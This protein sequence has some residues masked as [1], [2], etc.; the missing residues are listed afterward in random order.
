MT[1]VP[2]LLSYLRFEKIKT[3]LK[4]YMSMVSEH[5]ISF[6]FTVSLCFSHTALLH[7]FLCLQEKIAYCPIKCLVSMSISALK[8]LLYSLLHRGKSFSVA[9]DQN[10]SL[11]KCFMLQTWLGILFQ[12]KSPKIRCLQC[13]LIYLKVTRSVGLGAVA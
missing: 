10:L 5:Y 11:R 9:M 12:V 3:E 2:S 8:V 4:N 13:E 1:L 7:I 6:F